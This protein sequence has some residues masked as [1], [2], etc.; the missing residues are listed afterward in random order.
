MTNASGDEHT[1][2][3]QRGV[4]NA[5][6]YP[7]VTY[8]L[9]SAVLLVFFLVSFLFPLYWLL[10]LAVTPP[11]A[12]YQ[13]GLF[14]R[15]VTFVNFLYLL[16]PFG[17]APFVH[18]VFN[19]IVL[20][21]T[22]TLVVVCIATLTGYVF[23]RLE[24][25]GRR[26]LLLV[27]L[28]IAYFPPVAFLLPLFRLFTGNLTVLGLQSPDIYNTAGSIV[29]PL[30]ALTLPLAIFVLT[31]F[32]RQIPDT[33][34]DAARVE[35]TTRL[36]ALGR[37]I[38]PL[39][40]PGVATAAVLTFIQVYSEFFYSFLMNDGQVEHWAPIVPALVNLR[41]TGATFAAAGSVVA[42]LP[43]VVLVLLANEKLVRGINASRFG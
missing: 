2:V 12:T 6:R 42:L 30:S 4:R 43:V 17:R 27:T 37:V 21:V 16:D 23:G 35:G 31:T 14:P 39:S 20:S 29:L 13:L 1:G 19:S 22:T 8:R 38:L 7:G 32:F 40:G 41:D 3:L 24:F 26:V 25:P 11:N 9:L 33:L 15:E 5:I 18:Y 36:G 34:E 28:S 10:V